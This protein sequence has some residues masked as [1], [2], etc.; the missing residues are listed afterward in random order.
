MDNRLSRLSAGLCQASM[1]LYLVWLLLPAVQTTGGALAGCLC[2]A[3]FALGVVVDW[4]YFAA[5]WLSLLGRAACALVMPR[6]L[7]RMW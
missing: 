3:L 5:H 6:Q 7:G 4:P 1:F 2:V